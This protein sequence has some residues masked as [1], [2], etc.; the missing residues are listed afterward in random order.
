MRLAVSAETRAGRS[1]GDRAEDVH[2]VGGEVDGDADIA[3]PGRERAGAPARD[4][5]DV[6]QPAGLQQAPELED[7]GVEALDVAD[8]DRWGAGGRCRGDDP[9]RFGRGRR[10]RLLDEDRDAAPERGQGERQMRGGRGRD[11]DRVE[12]RLGQHGERLGE[13]LGAGPGSSRP[14]GLRVEV[15]DGDQSH[16]GQAAEDAEMVAAHRAEAD[17]PGA[18]LAVADR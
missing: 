12:V 16:V 8:L 3:D 6:R 7:G 5:K 13:R 11:H 4:R 14:E 2:V 10:Q 17:Q 15:G 9:V 18:Q 1:P